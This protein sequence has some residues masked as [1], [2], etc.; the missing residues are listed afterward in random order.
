L[1]H[2]LALDRL[3]F[4]K[5]RA[6][7]LLCLALFSGCATRQPPSAAPSPTVTLE[8][9]ATLRTDQFKLR[10]P[11]VLVVRNPRRSAIW[12]ESIECVLSV[13]GVEAGKLAYR[14]SRLVSAGS[15][16]SIP[17]E[18]AIDTRDLGQGISAVDGPAEAAWRME[19]RARVA[20]DGGGPLELATAA[21]GSFA[22]VREPGF[23]VKSVTIG[24]DRLVT[25]KLDLDL[26]IDNP[27]AFPISFSS[28]SYD[29]YGEGKIWADGRT[30]D[31]APIPAK[32][33]SERTLTFT[34]N[35]ASMDRALFDLVASLKIVRYRL[36]GEAR[37]VTGLEFLP[38]FATS[39]DIDGSCAVER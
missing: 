7:A 12:V 15:S 16:A 17:L 2:A 21:E 27:N 19:V 4:A 11:F 37:I 25:T 38:E 3:A 35:F 36:K 33:S 1:N 6:A 28:L 39:F 23:R 8:S 26:V 20:K 22:I 13:E 9:G 31:A 10:L 24:R 5:L 34:M 32:G 29:F 14:E 18:F 30:D